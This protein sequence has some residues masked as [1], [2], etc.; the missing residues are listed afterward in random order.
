MKKAARWTKDEES[1]LL[2]QYAEKGATWCAK[3]LRSL[4]Y[5]RTVVAVEC[6]ARKIGLMHNNMVTADEF[7]FL[8]AHFREKG[9]KW[10]AA[11]LGRP[12]LS[13]KN[14]AH[15]MKLTEKKEENYTDEEKLFVRRFY[16]TKGAR[17]C[18]EKLNRRRNAITQLAFAL[19]VKSK[20]FF[21]QKEDGVLRQ[22]YPALGAVGCAKLLSRTPDACQRRARRL[23]VKYGADVLQ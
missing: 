17:Y 9:A 22:K 7:D 11:Q 3:K 12:L 18:A 8:C 13:I 15:R 23:G 16:P 21:S 5:W 4:G 20:V 14:I 2:Q 10:C 19:G 1:I 6:K